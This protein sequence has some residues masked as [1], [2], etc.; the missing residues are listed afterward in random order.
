MKTTCTIV[1]TRLPG[2]DSV[3][4]LG[5]R[6]TAHIETCL[7][8]Q[9]EAARYRSLRRHLGALAE[10]TLEAPDT[11][12]PAVVAGMSDPVVDEIA[13]RRFT[14]R[15]AVAMSAAAGA[16]IAAAAGTAIVIG[17]RRAHKAA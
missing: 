3:D 1:Q 16:A 14:K 13:E 6:F 4:E 15:Q 2:V 7:S 11:L 10:E 9:A 8:C 12:V 5:D 17:L